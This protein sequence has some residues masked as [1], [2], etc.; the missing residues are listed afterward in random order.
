MGKIK[1][2]MV[3]EGVAA[4]KA[5]DASRS[6]RKVNVGLERERWVTMV[7][8]IGCNDEEFATMLLDRGGGAVTVALFYILDSNLGMYQK[9]I[10]NIFK[11]N[12]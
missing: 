12:L 6:A 2:K 7:S 4:K 10:T 1:Y 11:T 5:R 3:E 8:R 9:Y